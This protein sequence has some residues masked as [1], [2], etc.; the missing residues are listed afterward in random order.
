M[1]FPL[2]LTGC[3]AED[4]LVRELVRQR[5]AWHHDDFYNG[6][7]SQA[8]T[9]VEYVFARRNA[10]RSQRING[11]IDWRDCMRER[12]SAIMMV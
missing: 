2:V 1:I 6:N 8:R 10:A 11:A 7:M 4:P 3:M 12:W 9:Y 5:L